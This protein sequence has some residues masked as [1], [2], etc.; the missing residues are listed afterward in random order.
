M[1]KSETR[2][3]AETLHKNLRLYWKKLKNP[4]LEKNHKN[5]TSQMPFR[6]F[7]NE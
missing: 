3:D 1:V 7:E 4:K 5:E 6:Y 2:R